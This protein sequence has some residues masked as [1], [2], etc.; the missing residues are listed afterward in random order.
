MATSAEAPG[1]VRAAKLRKTLLGYVPIESPF[2]RYHPVTRLIMFVFFGVVPIFIDMPE[3]NFALVVCTILLLVWGQADLKRLR[4][5][6]PMIVT[7]A[8]FMFLVV[9]LAPGNDPTFTPIHIGPLTIYYQPVYF[10]FASYWRLMAMLFG[11]ILYFSTNRER[12]MLVALR[13]LK[14]PF[15]A[16][17]VVGFSI[18]AAGMFME[19]F[20]T[21]R[22]AEQARGLDKSALKL[23]DQV[24]L[25]VMYLVPLFS[26][27]LRRADE[28]S[29]ALFARGYNFTGRVGHG[30][31]R[32]DYILT[33]YTMTGMD[34]L[35]IAVLMT[36]FVG[37]A[38]AEYG[39]G[40]FRLP[41]SPINILL[42]H[43][44]GLGW[45]S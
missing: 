44:L 37:A 15:L 17:Y 41:H 14:L 34:W 33:Q 9:I 39:F 6:M 29:H 19:D 45:P 25:Y 35:V 12:D 31:K 38:V 1:G 22:E 28:I 40:A 10:T 20:N 43:L 3:I 7:I 23:G 21:I 24:K 2:Y 8:I 30:N 27:A 13:S 5:Y 26:I 32:S 11:T 18:R 16:S 4:I 42:H 36:L